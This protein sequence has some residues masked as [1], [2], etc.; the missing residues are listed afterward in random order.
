MSSI[1][2]GIFSL[3]FILGLLLMSSFT[4]AM[5]RIEEADIPRVT[6]LVSE[7]FE[8]TSMYD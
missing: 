5:S 6:R 7:I 4:K 1:G 3:G 2:T 8:K